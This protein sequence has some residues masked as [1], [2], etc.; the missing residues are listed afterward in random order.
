MNEDT[1]TS[2]DCKDCWFDNQF[3]KCSLRYFVLKSPLTRRENGDQ[4]DAPRNDGVLCGL[5]LQSDDDARQIAA[6]SRR[7]QAP[8]AHNA[9]INLSKKRATMGFIAAIVVL[10]LLIFFHE[11]GHF[12]AARALGVKV[13]TFSIGFGKK[14]WAKTIG[15]TEYAISAIWLG[16]YIKMKGQDDSDPTARSG[17]ADA[18]DSKKP[19][20]RIVI[21]FAGP[22]ANFVIAFTLFWITALIGFDAIAPTIGKVLEDS[23]ASGAGLQAGDT[24]TLI[25]GANVESWNQMS[26]LIRESQNTIELAIRRGG[27][28]LTIV[29]SPE[30]GEGENIF[31]EKEKRKMIGVSASDDKVTLRYGAIEGLFVAWHR[32]IDAGTLIFQSVIKLITGVL[33]LENVGGIVT[34]VDVMAKA[35]EIGLATLLIIAAVISVNLGVLNLL[36]I[37]ALDGGHIIFNLYEQITRR[38]P[39]ETILYRLTIGGWGVLCALMALGLYNDIARIMR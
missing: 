20:Q 36:P 7:R 15:G 38:A 30:L 24:I 32:T 17:E 21:L 1:L 34:V 27:E 29:L 9:K 39:N 37:P 13:E 4:S 33:G 14:L 18:F 26:A 11:L 8:I 10:S 28:T 5:I 22:F 31:G 19:W 6:R 35:S 16:G 2:Q 12:I 23:P 25:D 3:H